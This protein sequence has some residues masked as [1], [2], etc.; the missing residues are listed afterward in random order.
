MT[1]VDTNVVLDIWTQDPKWLSWSS[2]AFQQVLTSGQAVI[3]P[4]IAAEL[5]WGFSNEADFESALLRSNI[6]K[7]DL[8]CQT[9]F[10]AGQAYQL[11][12][13]RGGIKGR[14]LADFFIGAHAD[15]LGIPIVTRDPSG[16]RSYF[17]N[18]TL[19]CP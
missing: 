5:S 17:P 8:P 19:I 15:F 7:Y 14:V 10:L 11:Y 6:V 4:V 12:K 3:N 1:L 18:V 2:Q 13:K 16:Y 9:A